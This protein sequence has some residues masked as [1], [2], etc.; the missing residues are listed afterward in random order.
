MNDLYCYLPIKWKNGHVLLTVIW[1]GRVH[2]AKGRCRCRIAKIRFGIVQMLTSSDQSRAVHVHM[3]CTGNDVMAL[4]MEREIMI[5]G[6]RKYVEV[7]LRRRSTRIVPLWGMGREDH[8]AA[9]ILMFNIVLIVCL[10]V[11]VCFLV[12]SYWNHPDRQKNKTKQKKNQANFQI[13]K[14]IFFFFF[15]RQHN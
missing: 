13:W 5:A 6:I 3:P 10:F 2:N 7:V 14:G 8:M 4:C 15:G 12:S 11:F 9:S 1:T